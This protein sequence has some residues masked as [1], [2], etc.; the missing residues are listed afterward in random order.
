LYP[1]AFA[2]AEAVDSPRLKALFI[3]TVWLFLSSLAY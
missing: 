1:L 2:F 3:F